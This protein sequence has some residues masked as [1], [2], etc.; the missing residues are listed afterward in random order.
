MASEDWK[1]RITKVSAANA[2]FDNGDEAFG[3][4]ATWFGK[5][6]YKDGGHRESG[7]NLT[8]ASG[9]VLPD[10]FDDLKVVLV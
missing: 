6:A 7:S 8:A 10:Y 4:F 2:K 3:L 5:I 1:T 9:P